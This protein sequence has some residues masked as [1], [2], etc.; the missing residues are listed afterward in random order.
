MPLV[1]VSKSVQLAQA[2]QIGLFHKPEEVVRLVYMYIPLQGANYT[3]AQWIYSTIKHLTISP[4]A[5]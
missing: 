2:L 1:T 4:V 5:A 3:V